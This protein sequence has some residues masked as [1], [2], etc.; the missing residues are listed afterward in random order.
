MQKNMTT[1][2]P[3]VNLNPKPY[4]GIGLEVWV[5]YYGSKEFR[6][7]WRWRHVFFSCFVFSAG[8]SAPS[9]E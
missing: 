3:V 2:N 8:S 6:R 4:G 9:K 1:L 7:I 5:D